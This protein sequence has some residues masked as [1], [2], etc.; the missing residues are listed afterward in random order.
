MNLK[1][2]DCK[3]VVLFGTFNEN[4]YFLGDYRDKFDL[5]GFNANIVAHAPD[6]A[7]AFISRLTNKAFFIDPQT[8][9]FQQPIHTIMRKKDGQWE[10]KKSIVTLADHYGSIIRENVGSNQIKAGSLKNNEIFE[11]CSNTLSFQRNLIQESAENLDVKEFLE[12]SQVELR[13][14]FFIAPYFYMEPDKLAEELEDNINFIA[15]SRNSLDK[16]NSPSNKSLFAEIILHQEILYDVNSTDKILKKYTHCD[17]DGFLVWIDDFSEVSVS[18]SAL[19]KYKEFLYELGKKGRPI[20]ALHGSYYSIAL[21]GE[22]GLLAGVGHGIEYGES[23]PI[24][25]VGGGVPLAK[26]YFPK[27]HKRIDYSPDAEDILKEKEWHLNPRMYFDNVCSCEMCKKIIQKDV[28]QNFHEYGKTKKSEKNG[29]LYP[30]PEAM[31]KSRKH[32]LNTKINEYHRCRSV[33]ISG[34]ISE[35]QNSHTIAEKISSHPFTHL[36]RWADA[37]ST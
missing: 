1:N 7:A 33:S 35:I 4:K 28:E 6:G 29:K 27:F 32:Y 5:V 17:A 3:H 8:H 20:I 26:F 25:P 11:I 13:P 2:G 10:L 30:T 16:D 14:S 12:F 18:G 15:E 19:K 22:K 21:S 36:Q 37:L 9:A 34:I 23:R 24:V 31:D